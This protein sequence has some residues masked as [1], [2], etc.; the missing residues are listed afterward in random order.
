MQSFLLYGYGG[1]LVRPR[2]VENRVTKRMVVME[3]E[4]GVQYRHTG[5]SRRVTVTTL[6]REVRVE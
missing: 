3:E 4:N 6:M 2:V 5:R 1:G